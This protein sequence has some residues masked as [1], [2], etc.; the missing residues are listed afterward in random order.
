M[1][2][3]CYSNCYVAIHIFSVS[4][5]YMMRVIR[6]QANFDNYRNTCIAFYNQLATLTARRVQLANYAIVS[7]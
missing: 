7:C 5:V 2:S 4:F 3:I 1:Y 6:V